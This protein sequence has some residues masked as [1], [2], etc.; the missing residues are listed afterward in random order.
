M[1]KLIKKDKR[2]LIVLYKQMHE[3][4]LLECKK[5]RCPFSCCDSFA[6]ELTKQ[7][8]KEFWNIDLIPTDNKKLPFMSEIGC[9]VS[10]HLRPSCTMHT[11]E[12]NSLGIKKNDKEW[13]NKYFELRNKI[14][15]IEEK[16]FGDI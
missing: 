3:L 8:A 4:T 16:R 11:C 15:I 13:T 7:Y 10:P 14:E 2:K 5:C 1:K 12:I 9:I 6:C